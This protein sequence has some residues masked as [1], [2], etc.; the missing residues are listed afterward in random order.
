MASRKRIILLLDGTWNDSDRGLA[1]TNI[2]RLRQIIS[3]SLEPAMKR[4]GNDK[5]SEE[6]QHPTITA[7]SAQH[8]TSIS[9][10][11]YNDKKHLVFYERGVGTG[12]F[13][14]NYRGGAFGSGLARNVRRAY[15]F[16]S[17]NYK[18]G[19]EVFIFGFSR[20]SY[21]AR[22][23]VGL[24]GATGLLKHNFCSP[25]LESKTWYFYRTM[26]Q[27]RLPTVLR[28]LKKYMHGRFEVSCLGVF[29]T[30]GALGVPIGL[31]WR[32]NRD[33]YGFHD[34]SL[35]GISAFNLHALAVDE[36]RVTFEAAPWRQQAFETIAT[37]T[38]Q[39]WFPGAHSDVGGGYIIEEQRPPYAA[40]LDDITLDWML[41]RVT[42]RYK[43]F[44]AR[45]GSQFGWPYIDSSDANCVAVARARQHEARR[46]IYRMWPTALRS[47][48]NNKLNGTIEPFT[49]VVCYDRHAKSLCEMIHM[50]VLERLGGNVMVNAQSKI[51]APVNVLSV[52]SILKNTYADGAIGPHVKL[53][54]WS[55]EIL[56]PDDDAAR[57]KAQGKI[58]A[59]QAR[60]GPLLPNKP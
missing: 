3:K 13:L 26:P 6:E 27:D 28:S 42:A 19:D 11:R 46:H 17:T 56:N 10:G 35:S 41:K 55:A 7:P 12:G 53:V 49:K 44:P 18:P 37:Q 24:I 43:D 51:Y 59:A 52:L 57:K 5:L 22:S 60:I 50:S 47:I 21:T 31:F 34:V 9:I 1:D 30:V 39:V 15:I 38:E 14:D 58:A 54:D 33:L 29:D 40:E 32:E 36:H 45:P 4:D 8:Q 25:E 20:G 48:A 23:L 16:L 2:V